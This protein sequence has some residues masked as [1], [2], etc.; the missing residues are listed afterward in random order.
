MMLA[1]DSKAW[2]QTHGRCCAHSD[3]GKDVEAA[4]Q[5]MSAH[6]LAE[7]CSPSHGSPTDSASSLHADYAIHGECTRDQD[8][9]SPLQLR[10]SAIAHLHSS[11]QLISPVLVWHA[12]RMRG[13]SDQSF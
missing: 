11:S 7:P 12:T 13:V 1:E 3:A 8:E 2:D 6:R 4:C 10:C 9:T 5:L